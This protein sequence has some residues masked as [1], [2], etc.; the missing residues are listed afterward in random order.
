MALDYLRWS[1]KN[2]K[3][4]VAV[5]I[6]D[7][8]DIVNFEV[9]SSYSFNKSR[10]RAERERERFRKIFERAR[11]KLPKEDQNKVR[12]YKWKEV[13]ESKYYEEIYK[14]LLE[15][16]KQMSEF[17]SGVLFFVKKYVR[18]RRK[19]KVLRDQKKLDKLATYILGELPTLLQGIYLD[20]VHYDLCI[21][22]TYFASGMSQF[23]TDIFERELDISKELLGKLKRRAYLVE[24]WLD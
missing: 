1:V 23:V 18:R 14:Y 15:S 11:S 20:G 24:V 21:Y 2:T 17:R 22:P 4:K 7:E 3:E 16:Y 19:L 5:I 6:A 13:R 8:L 12:I 10:K 9:F